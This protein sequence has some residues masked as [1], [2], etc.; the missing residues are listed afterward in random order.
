MHFQ[1]Q[2]ETFTTST[3]KITVSLAADIKKCSFLAHFERV[4]KI[5]TALCGE[6]DD[7]SGSFELG[8]SP[9]GHSLDLHTVA[10]VRPHAVQ[11]HLALHTQHKERKRESSCLF[12]KENIVLICNVGLSV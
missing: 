12:S 1:N 8:L 10:P 11:L 5:H 6:V 3:E 4:I 9:I 7:G 2:E